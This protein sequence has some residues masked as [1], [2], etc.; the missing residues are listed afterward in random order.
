MAA[1]G[2]DGIPLTADEHQVQLRRAVIA[3]TIRLFPL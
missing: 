3:S 1:L 2:V